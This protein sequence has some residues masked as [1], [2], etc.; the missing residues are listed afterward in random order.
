[1]MLWL[2]RLSREALRQ[3]AIEDSLRKAIVERKEECDSCDG[4]K[5]RRARKWSLESRVRALGRFRHP[6]TCVS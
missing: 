3:M 6:G 4:E 1:M 2:A 5:V